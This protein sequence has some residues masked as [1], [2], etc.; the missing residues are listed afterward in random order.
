[1]LNLRLEFEKWR[2]SEMLNTPLKLQDLPNTRMKFEN[3]KIHL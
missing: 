3:S 2:K 1:M